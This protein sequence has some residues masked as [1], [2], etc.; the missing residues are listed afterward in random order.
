M[1]AHQDHL[2]FLYQDQ[3]SLNAAFT[4]IHHRLRQDA[5]E[6]AAMAV[7]ELLPK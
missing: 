6:H 7:L 2:G 3:S 4:E 1:Q 5:S